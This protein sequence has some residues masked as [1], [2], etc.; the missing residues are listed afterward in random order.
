[1]AEAV[2]KATGRPGICFVTR[3]PGATNA[4]PG[5]HIA[6]QDS[7]PMILFVGQVARDVRRSARRC[8]NSTTAPCSAAW[9]NGRPKS[10]I[11]ARVPEIVSRAFYAA[12]GGRPGPVVIGLP[13]DM[14]TRARRG[15]GCA[16]RSKPVETW[17]GQPELAKLAELARAGRAADPDPR[18]QPLDAS[19]ACAA[20]Q[21]I[22]PSGSRCRSRPAIGGCRCS[23]RCIPATPATSASAANPK[24]VARV[25]GG[26]PRGAASAAG[27]AKL[28]SQGYTLFDIPAPQTKLVH[29]HPGAEELGR[30]LPA[31]SGDPRGA[32]RFAAALAKRCSAPASMSWREQTAAAHAR[33]SGVDATR[34]PTSRA[35]SIS[36]PS[37]SGCAKISPP[38]RS[39]ATAPAIMPPGSIASIASAVLPRTSRRPRPRWDTACP[40]AVAMK[41]LYPDRTVHLGQRRRRFPDERPGVRDRRAVRAADHRHRLR[42]RHLRHDPDAPGARISR[43]RLRDRT[44]QSRISPPMPARSAASA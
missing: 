19:S 17:P 5:I 44:A 21:P 27:S 2:G 26:R 12:T 43:P 13:E 38:T 8:R 9:R 42:Q 35:A 7:T 32:D 22:S 6:Q 30:R 1:M 3:G 36:A 31:A 29:I 10:T 28:P 14:L 24:L 16:A 41:R 33:L 39:C 23:I 15:R 34:R 25:E 18:R 37:W 11:A 20:M 4:S 40:A